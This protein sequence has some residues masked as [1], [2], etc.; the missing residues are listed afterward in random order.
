PNS[1]G[2]ALFTT[3]FVHQFCRDQRTVREQAEAVITLST[4]HGL[5]FWLAG[6]S[7]FRG[8]T[9]VEQG[10][11]EEGIKQLQQGLAIWQAT[12]AEAVR[13]HFLALLAEAYGK[14]RQT[15]EGLKTL[16]E[17]LLLIDKTGE[18]VYEAEVYRLKGELTLQQASAQ[19]RAASVQK[20]AEEDF[21]KAIEIARQQ[22]AK[23]LELRATMSL[24]RLW[25]SQGKEAEAHKML[26]DVY[27]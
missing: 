18:R 9:L 26:S 21:E 12:G 17:A 24:A 13:P 19:H 1:L 14:T 27:N 5:P 22:Q 3:C 15:E 25:Q 10:Q 16:A 23:S 4:E 20:E 8:W 6:G 2:G 11:G 7:I